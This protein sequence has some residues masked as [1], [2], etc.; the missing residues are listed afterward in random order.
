MPKQRTPSEYKSM[1]MLIRAVRK[2]CH[3]N[4]ISG[5]QLTKETGYTNAYQILD[6]NNE[7][8][9]ITHDTEMLMRLWLDE[10]IKGK[11]KQGELL[12]TV[13]AACQF[14]DDELAKLRVELDAANV[15]ISKLSN[16]LIEGILDG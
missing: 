13:C 16:K 2:Y 9:F 3:D 15:K 10:N 8:Q 14:K 7:P 1:V 4:H 11:P 6:A 12:P 5:A